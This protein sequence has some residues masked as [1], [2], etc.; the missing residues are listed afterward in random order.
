MSYHTDKPNEQTTFHGFPHGNRYRLFK[1]SS[2]ELDD[3][4]NVDGHASQEVGQ[5]VITAWKCSVQI[6]KKKNSKVI[7]PS[8]SQTISNKKKG[9]FFQLPSLTTGVG[10][11]AGRSR[12][13][14]KMKYKPIS[15]VA[16]QKI[17][18]ETYETLKLRKI[19]IP[20]DM[21]TAYFALPTPAAPAAPTVDVV[22][23]GS[24]SSSSSSSL[25]VNKRKKPTVE[26]GGMVVIPGGIRKKK[27]LP[28][29]IDLT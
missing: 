20:A 27:K 8:G 16:T 28:E 15:V 22:K 24:S 5:L 26:D 2:A 17:F 29:T 10:Q 25:K 6:K 11:D 9:K 1:F 21:V 4:S 14:A 12:R 18:C 19:P 3:G 13:R 23:S 7:L